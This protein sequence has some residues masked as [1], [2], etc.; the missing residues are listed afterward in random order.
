MAHSA[1]VY[2]LFNATNVCKTVNDSKVTESLRN[3]W[4]SF[5]ISGSRPVLWITPHVHSEHFDFSGNPNN[6]SQ[7][8]QAEWPAFNSLNVS[9]TLDLQPV[10]VPQLRKPQCNFW[11]AVSHGGLQRPPPPPPAGCDICDTGK[12][13]PCKACASSKTGP[14]APCWAPDPSHGGQSCLKDDFTGCRRCWTQH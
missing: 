1:D 9:M 8:Q 10:A 7:I 6:A 4:H 14:C 2:L 12:C 3:Y 13:A 11:A 5:S